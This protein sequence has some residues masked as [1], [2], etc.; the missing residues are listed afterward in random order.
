MVVLLLIDKSSYCLL[1]SV[2]LQNINPLYW[3]VLEI[4]RY[5]TRT[6]YSSSITITFTQKKKVLFGVGE[7]DTVALVIKT[8]VSPFDPQIF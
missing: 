2:L 6:S 8:L 5:N 7:G 4:K 1:S 3:F